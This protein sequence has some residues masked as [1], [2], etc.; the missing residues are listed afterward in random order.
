MSIDAEGGQGQCRAGTTRVGTGQ[1]YR[2]REAE[3]GGQLIDKGDV[4]CRTGGAGIRDVELQS[5]A[6]AG[7][8]RI[9][10]KGLGE[11]GRAADEEGVHSRSAGDRAAAHVTA[12]RAG[13]VG[14]GAVRC[15]TR[16]L[17]GGGEGTR[18]TWGQVATSQGQ[19]AGAGQGG[20]CAARIR[21]QGG[22]GQTRQRCVQIVGKGDV[23]GAV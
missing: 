15:S 4:G 19:E 6:V 1:T 10:C 8:D 20:A 22:C 13:G 12:Q 23:G 7:S 14:I 9:I 18:R 5:D 3:E 11:D 21:R 16:D 17:K 2:Y